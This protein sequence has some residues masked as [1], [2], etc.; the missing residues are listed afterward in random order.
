M[1]KH[2]SE[3]SGRKTSGKGPA[4]GY[5]NYPPAEPEPGLDIRRW[6]QIARRRGPMV[7]AVAVLCA[8]F[9]AIYAFQ[10]SPRYTATVTLMVDPRQQNVMSSE[11][12]VS[13]LGTDSTAIESQVELIRS[14]NV[15]RRVAEDLKLDER[16]VGAARP[17]LVATLFSL[18]SPSADTRQPTLD[19]DRMRRAVSTLQDNVQVVRQNFTYI[20]DIR[21]TSESPALAAQIANAFADEYLVDQLEAR[22]DTTRRANEWLETRLSELRTR[23]RE[24]E[25]AVEMFKAEHN[26]VS[27]KGTRL[28]DEQIA[29]LNEQLIDARAATAQA[30]VKYEQL[31]NVVDSGGD[32]SSFAETMQAQVI[33]LLRTKASE[34]KRQ[35]AELSAKYGSKHPQVVSARAQLADLNRQIHDQSAAIVAAA[36]ND[37]QVAQSRQASIQQSLQDLQGEFESGNT[38]EIQ[39]RELEREA[40]ANR[41]LFEAFLTRFK[42]TQQQETL[43]LSDTRIIE[44]ASV[45]DRPS[46]PNKKVFVLFGLLLGIGFGGGLAFVLEKLDRGFRSTDQIEEALGVPVLASIPDVS[47]DTA[48]TGWT[49]RVQR[50]LPDRI[51]RA[52]GN[53]DK[54]RATERLKA[55]R[56]VLDKPLSSFTE[57]IRSLRLGMRYANIDKP[58]RVV[59]VTSALPSEGKTTIAS[60]LAQHAA[61][62][63]ERVLLLDMDLRHPAQTAI[64][65]PDAEEGLVQI[66]MSGLPVDSVLRSDE[67]SKLCFIPA[68]RDK[69]L[70]HTAEILSAQRMRDFIEEM[71]P[72]FDLI[73]IDS[74]PL[75][76]VIDGRVLIDAVDG[77]LLVV[78]WEKTARDAVDAAIRQSHGLEDKLIG[79]AFNDVVPEKARYYDYYKSGYYARKY[80]YYYDEKG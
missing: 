49:G 35:L 24:S 48:R 29:R 30:R 23:V 76:P 43:Q 67:R 28:S 40:E 39:L 34:V 54:R 9:G 44:R 59:L 5:Y 19:D 57:A 27:A 14:A 33:G 52:L 74:S 65:A 75:L 8:L 63:G 79:V 17:G 62:T 53:E 18:L 38:A 68:P 12:V 45:P 56:L 16:D 36:L 31:Q 13:G 77:V 73:V 32:P 4:T 37:Y 70:T 3:N 51:A 26:I 47:G 61:Y 64:Y 2:V 6:I 22:Y 1:L 58:V 60:N 21:Y 55:A 66:V 7:L 42:E 11:A 69:A 80:P 25:R 71:K 72:L 10:L 15:A 46:A 50:L 78:Q 20:I 41:T